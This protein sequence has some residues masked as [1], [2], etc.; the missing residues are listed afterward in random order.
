MVTSHP[1]T[2]TMT[3]R[4]TTPKKIDL[5]PFI[6]R[7]YVVDKA[8]GVKQ[9]KDI[10]HP[11]QLDIIELVNECI[12]ERKPCRIIVLK[13]RQIGMSTIIEAIQFTLSFL[14]RRMRGLVL[15]QDL[16]NS[17]HLL[18]MTQNYFDTFFAADAYTQKN[19][20]AKTLSWV[21][22]GSSIR[23]TTANNKNSGRGRTLHFLHAS[24]VGFWD[25]AETLMTGLAQALPPIPNTFIF[26]ESTANGLGN[27]FHK[28][29]EAACSNDIDY[30]PRFYPWWTHPEYKGSQ[31]KLPPIAGA[32][33]DEE[34]KLVK[35]FKNPPK[36]RWNSFKCEPLD[37]EE[38]L[39]R[40]IWRRYAIRNLCEGDI[41]RFHQEYPATP[42]EA[43]LSTGQNVFPAEEL[44]QVFD[45]E[46]PRVGEMVR[47][48][49]KVRFQ[50]SHR[51]HFKL[52]REPVPGHKYLV[53]GD[54]KRATIG[55]YSCAQVI[56]R[57]TWEQVG[58]YRCKTSDPPS[59][60]QMM[61]NIGKYYNTAL[62]VNE[63]EGGGTGVVA[64]MQAQGYPYIWRHKKAERFKGQI[65]NTYGWSTNYRTKSEALGNLLKCIRDQTITIHDRD[66]YAELKNYVSLAGGK[67]GNGEDTDHDDTVMA[68]SIGITVTIY[69]SHEIVSEMD[70][71]PSTFNPTIRREAKLK[72]QIKENIMADTPPWENW[73]AEQYGA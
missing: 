51:G 52:Y 24:E 11:A 69:E 1:M 32:L 61:M 10:I 22:T 56:D 63:L 17:E 42:D 13:A 40:L 3:T 9:L 34:K 30:V 60:G 16:D 19:R 4:R 7:L 5:K 38:I 27:Y 47:E 66:T 18:S 64:V 45:E 41:N 55:D 50:A 54:P 71:E 8:L 36:A 59:F 21:E 67:F 44:D 73:G 15:S 49:E 53:A 48:G 70:N 20:S 65:D 37:S 26:L 29:W 72:P 39:D 25:N 43:F 31:L 35:L 28:T 62:L 58:V 33:D 14:M 2:A 46:N 6:M 23:I 68:L 57:H 12:N